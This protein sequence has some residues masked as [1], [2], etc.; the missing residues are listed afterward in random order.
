M[1][2]VARLDLADP[3][4]VTQHDCVVG[5][6]G[7]L[8]IAQIF[9]A[10]HLEAGNW[11]R[12]NPSAPVVLVPQMGVVLDAKTQRLV[13]AHRHRMVGGKKRPA[14]GIW[15]QIG[16]STNADA[17]GGYEVNRPVLC[18]RRAD[19]VEAVIFAASEPVTRDTLAHVIGKGCNST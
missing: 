2:A 3:P 17:A 18:L 6:I 5:V 9:E 14:V 13:N 1:V 10:T 7:T 8:A 4:V 15:L 11:G 19:R 12:R 16:R